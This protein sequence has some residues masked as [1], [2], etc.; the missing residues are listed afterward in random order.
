MK[1]RLNIEQHGNEDWPMHNKKTQEDEF[2]AHEI[3][4]QMNADR[5]K[6][7][8]LAKKAQSDER[9]SPVK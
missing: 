6:A 5:I 2:K 9:Q 1:D 4:R 7:S 3:A 8:E